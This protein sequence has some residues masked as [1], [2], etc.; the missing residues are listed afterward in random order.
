MKIH[1]G[2]IEGYRSVIRSR[3]D[4]DRLSL[5]YD[6]PDELNQEKIEKIKNYFLENLYPDVEKRKTLNEAFDTLDS[7]IKKPQKLLNILITSSLL[8]LKYGRSLPKILSVGIKALKSYRSANIFE[9]HLAEAAKT[10][11]KNPPFSNEEIEQFISSLPKEKV[12][13]FIDESKS[14]FEVLYDRKLVAKILDIANELIR[15]MKKKPNLYSQ[16]EIEGIALG[17]Q[18][19]EK[20]NELFEELS[21]SSRRAV[22]D[23]TIEIERLELKR[24]F[25]N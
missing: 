3:Y 17:L 13:Q 10:S 15:K 2:I 1:D 19:I 12:E 14:L 5:L 6:I 21:P 20:G 11:K 23:K 7:Y 16:E 4:Y 8:L 18:I 24:I 9:N 25:E 22:I